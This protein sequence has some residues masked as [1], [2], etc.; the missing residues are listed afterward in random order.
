MKKNGHRRGCQMY[1][2][3]VC[4]RQFQGG[5]QID[6]KSCW[7]SYVNGKLT[8]KELAAM[9]GCS[10]R[11][12]S[13]RISKVT[14]EFVPAYPKGAVVIM[15]TTYFGRKFGVMLFQDAGSGRILYRK[16]VRNETN[17]GY[18]SGLQILKDHGVDIK[19]VVCDGR[20]GLLEGIIGI[21]AQMCQFHQLQ[22]IRRTLTRNPQ[23][24]AGCELLSLC[25]TIKSSTKAEFSRLFDEWCGKWKDFLDERTALVSGKTTY[26]HRR[27]RSARKTI[28]KH[29]PWLFT[30]EEYPDYDI[31]NTSNKLEGTNSEMKRRLHSHNG[32]TEQNKKKFID[33]FLK[34]WEKRSQ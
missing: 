25:L 10:A 1:K 22:I 34:T 4:G 17:E 16:Y 8:Y 20:V 28:A 26:T 18:M 21:P 14:S 11:T 2:C 7:A 5:R 15:D 29:L 19:A 24:L 6:D 13:R 12:I 23:L 33:E 27:L 31:P 3:H 9:Y 32:L 30:Y